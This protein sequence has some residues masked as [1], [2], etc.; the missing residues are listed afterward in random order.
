MLRFFSA[1]S[2]NVNS[3]KAIRECLEKA[4]QG[5]SELNCD[6]I[7][8]YSTAGHN[9]DELLSE[10]RRISPGVRI[11]GCSG[12]GI[13]GANGPSESMKALA[14]MA[15]K[16]PPNEFVLCRRK[17][18]EGDPYRTALE[19]SIELKRQAPGITM[20]QL[21]S[22]NMAA[23]LF[24]IEKALEG[25]KSIFGSNI[26]VSGGLAM[27]S[28]ANLKAGMSTSS[29]LFYDYEILSDGAV[30]IGYADP[31]LK[32]FNRANHGF[33]ILE[34][35]TFEVTK[36]EK[37]IVLEINGKPAWNL[38]TETL[39]IPETFTPM[40]LLPITGFARMLPEELW[41][42]N[43]SKYLISVVMRKNDDGSV[44]FPVT[45]QVGTKFWLTKRDEMKMFQGIDLMTGRIVKQ[46]DGKKPEAV[47][48][49][50]CTLRGRFS[51]DTVQKEE[52][53]NAIQH[54]ICKGEN[55]PWLGYYSGGEFAMIGNEAWFQQLSSS[56]FVIYR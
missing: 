43:G 7:I 33:E 28:L 17:S 38:I 35:L 34:Y 9:L 48:Q 5:E 42:E 30:M 16:G 1:S 53:T 37:N 8:L 3:K 29:F 39:G 6:L 44:L 26:P 31:T 13:I 14:V 52:I 46:L 55:V 24:P 15:I 25:L 36:A 32:F 40:Q 4:L 49:T 23:G 54:P 18:A 45:F 56:I 27:S 12:G 21:Y 22:A 41:E 11:A 51:V 47:F 20:V 19:M 10:A 2:N 50:D